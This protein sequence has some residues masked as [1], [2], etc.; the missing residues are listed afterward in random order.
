M[1]DKMPKL[2]EQFDEEKSALENTIADA[3][4]TFSARTGFIVE[5][6]TPFYHDYQSQGQDPY[7]SVSVK[8][9]T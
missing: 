2:K 6:I 9:K 4:I 7:Y 3:V 5:D 1:S 8:V